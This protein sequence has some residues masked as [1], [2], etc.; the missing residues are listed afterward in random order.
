MAVSSARYAFAAHHSMMSGGSVWQYFSSSH[1]PGNQFDLLFWILKSE[2]INS[3]CLVLNI[4]RRVSILCM[5]W[6]RRQLTEGRLQPGSLGVAQLIHFLPCSVN[7][8]GH[9]SFETFSCTVCWICPWTLLWLLDPPG[10]TP[11]S[12]QV[13]VVLHC[14][15]PQK[16]LCSFK[17]WWLQIWDLHN[18]CSPRKQT[19]ICHSHSWCINSDRA[20]CVFHKSKTPVEVVQGHR[21]LQWCFTA[22]CR[23]QHALRREGMVFIRPKGATKGKLSSHSDMASPLTRFMCAAQERGQIKEQRLLPV[24]V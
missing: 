13:P 10:F 8:L 16:Q 14:G 21:A 15:C 9:Q 3:Y 11:H 23:L 4:V 2:T 1:F 6:C 24:L 22:F 17:R 7:P 12:S 5:R 18:L 19:C 20:T